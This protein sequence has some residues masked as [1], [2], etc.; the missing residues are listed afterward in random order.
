[1]PNWSLPSLGGRLR[2]RFENSK[3]TGAMPIVILTQVSLV[4]LKLGAQFSKY[5]VNGHTQVRA[6]TGGM[7]SPSGQG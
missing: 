3:G 6:N 4:F 5:F 1:V 2:V 7:N